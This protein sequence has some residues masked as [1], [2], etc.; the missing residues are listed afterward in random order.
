VLRYLAPRAPGPMA[1][2]ASALGARDAAGGVAQLVADLDLPRHLA[3]WGLTEAD[4]VE[5]A[6]P[7]A[8]AEHREE[9]LVSILRAAM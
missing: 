6:R 3:A 9:D 4:L 5:A 7:L 2:I 8:S 1:R